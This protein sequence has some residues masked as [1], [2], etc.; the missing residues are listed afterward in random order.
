MRYKHSAIIC[1]G[2][3]ASVVYTGH[4]YAFGHDTNEELLEAVRD[5]DIA[6]AKSLL[7]NKADVNASRNDGT[8][9]LAWSVYNNNEDMVDLL[10]RSGRDGAD[11]NAANENGVS[12]LH[13]A[14]I[15]QNASVVSKLLR[16]GADPNVKKWTGE[17]PLMT[18]SN[19][20][21]IEGLSGLL[22]NGA[23]VNVRENTNNQTALMWAAAEGHGDVVK[24][25]IARGADLNARSSTVM[26]PEPYVVNTESTMGQNFPKSTRFRKYTGNFTALLFAAQSGDVESAMHI[27]DAGAD[28]NDASDE[29][30]S[31]LLIAT[32]SGHEDMALF[33]LEQG[34]DP[35]IVNAW[36]LAPLHYTVHKGILNM[37]NWLSTKTDELGWIHEPMHRL[38]KALLSKGGSPDAPVLYTLPYLD[39]PFLRVHD[40]QSQ[41]DIVGSTPLLLAAAS[42]D[43]ES[44]RIMVKAGADINAKTMGGGTLFMLAAGGGAERRGRDEQQAIEA[45]KYVLSLGGIDINAQLTDNRTVNGPGKGKADGRSIMHFITTLGWKDMVNFLAEKGADLNAQ[46]R[47]GMTPLMIAMGDPESRYYRNVGVGR[48]DDRYRRTL[49]KSHGDIEK[50]LLALGANPFTGTIVSKGSVD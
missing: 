42:G 34:A 45:A 24:A 33:L 31:A 4:A 48:Y 23:D 16:A 1:F 3:I 12:P 41:I 27:L 21:T 49:S 38:M 17:T 25:L 18:C 8:T 35:N 10:I 22:A 32:A 40:N 2:I 28:I 26:E 15:N 44:L 47:Y 9:A 13:L 6:K 7:D 19:T 50:M 46:D 36:G 5:G 29:D 11:V 30:G 37:S 20:G 14:C 43:T 39:D